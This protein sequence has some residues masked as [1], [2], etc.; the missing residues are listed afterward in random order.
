MSGGVHLVGTA[1]ELLRKKNWMGYW[2]MGWG[3]SRGLEEKRKSEKDLPLTRN[4]K[5]KTSHNKDLR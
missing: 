5:P 3:W 2:E 1:M 4:F